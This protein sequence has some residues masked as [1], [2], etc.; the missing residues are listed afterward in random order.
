V[1]TLRV[2]PSGHYW[3]IAGNLGGLAIDADERALRSSST[4]WRTTVAD[5][6]VG[7]IPLTGRLWAS[8]SDTAVIVVHG[9]GGN[10]DSPYVRAMSRA[11]VDRGWT[12]LRYNMRGADLSGVDL[13]HAGLYGDLHAAAR[14]R[15]LARHRR[16]FVVGYSLGGHLGLRLAMDPG[17]FTAVV[18]VCPPFDLGVSQRFLDTAR[19]LVYRHYVLLAL[20]Q[21]YKAGRDRRETHPTPWA[22]VRLVRTIRAWD[23]VSVVPR[24]GFG[25]ADEYYR[26]QSAGPRLAELQLPT[27]ILHSDHDPMIPPGTQQPWIDH[28]HPQLEVKRLKQ[29]GHVIFPPGVDLGFGGPAGVERQL[30]RWLDRR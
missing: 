13:Y 18:A 12:C 5:P 25:T 30:C 21:V 24:F 28:A 20:K 6:D 15:E 9:L 22:K 1:S 27:L 3:T 23:E 10:A 11:V 2:P 7:D 4:P 8:D 16:I 17:P 29:G 26:S 19:G 14:S